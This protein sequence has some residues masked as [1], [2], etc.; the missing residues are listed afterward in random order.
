MKFIFTYL[1]KYI[2]MVI[3]IIVLKIAATFIELLIPYVLKHLIDDVAPMK[4]LT[5][6][7]SG[8]LLCSRWRS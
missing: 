3:G 1:K 8:A 5:L 7:L 6:I 2:W 4:N